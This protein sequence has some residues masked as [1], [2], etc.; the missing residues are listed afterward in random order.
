MKFLLN[1]F[2]FFIFKFNTVLKSLVWFEIDQNTDK[3]I[4]IILVLHFHIL[5]DPLKIFI[6]LYTMY[7]Y[8]EHLIKPQSWPRIQS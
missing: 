8:I 4:M 5:N 2:L 6:Y 1:K 7:V 3:I